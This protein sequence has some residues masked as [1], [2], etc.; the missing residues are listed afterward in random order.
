MN[1]KIT[2]I[3]DEQEEGEGEQQLLVILTKWKRKGMAIT[4]SE[5]K[6]RIE[7]RNNNIYKWTRD[8]EV[9][10]H[11]LLLKMYKGLRRGAIIVTAH[12]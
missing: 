3:E 8:R 6:L 10:Q 7:E 11:Q 9:K 12:E 4:T 1:K 5:K 2:T